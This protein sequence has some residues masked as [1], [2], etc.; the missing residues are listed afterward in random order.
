MSWD[1]LTMT[2]ADGGLGFRK[3]H[4]FNLSVLGKQAWKLVTEPQT[5]FS[6]IIKAKYFPSRSFLNAELG[7]NPSYT[8][9]SLWSTQDVL[10]A[11]C[12]WRLGDGS[13][14][15]VWK[16]PGIHNGPQMSLRSESVVNL[17]H[18]RVSSLMLPGQRAW[19]ENL[20]RTISEQEDA[21]TI[22]SMPLLASV[23]EDRIIWKHS[24]NGLYTVKSAYF[25]IRELTNPRSQENA[26]KD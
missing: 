2:K 24:S 17:E 18:I 9:K 26:Q 16:E 25:L 11:G 1:I 13:S 4:A 6:R 10:R 7:H 3:L 8:W 15:P 21:N 5:L 23:D 19:N 20:V 22:L 12:R 14:I